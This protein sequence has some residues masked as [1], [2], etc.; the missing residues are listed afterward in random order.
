MRAGRCS[1][2]GPRKTLVAGL[3]K[4]PSPTIKLPPPVIGEGG[5][6]K[7]GKGKPRT[8]G[9]ESGAAGCSL[10]S[11]ASRTQVGTGYLYVTR[12]G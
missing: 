7:K 10:C 4:R 11:V 12:G 8:P 1:H 2:D 5:E 6:V 3:E 9:A